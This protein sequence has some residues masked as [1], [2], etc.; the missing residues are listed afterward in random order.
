MRIAYVTTDPGIPPFGTKG[1]SI[2]V[3]SVLRVLLA[4]G[5]QVTLFSPCLTI[6]LAPEFAP[7]TLHPLPPAPRGDD[8]EAR[9]AWSLS[10]NETLAK[11]LSEAG[12]FDLVYER[13]ALF[14]HAAMEFAMGAGIPSALELNAPLIA[15][16]TRHRR[17]VRQPDAEASARRAFAAARLVAAVSPA[18]ADYARGFGAPA[19]RVAVIPNGVEAGR[20]ADRPARTGPFTVGFVG[21]LKPWHD[22]ATLIEAFALLKRDHL[23]EARL[24]IVGDGPQQAPIRARLDE[25]SLTDAA[26]LTGAVQ[27]DQVPGWLA[28]MHVATA[29]YRGDQPF[30][31][32]PLKLYEYMAAALPVVASD[33]GDLAQVLDHGRLGVI[34]PPDDPAALAHALAGLA[35][36]PAAAAQ[37]GARARAE[38]L[39][40]HGWDRIVTQIL[41]RASAPGQEAA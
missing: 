13:H 15:E 29:P 3:Q 11:A 31:F 17:M 32:S 16:Q 10:L 37:M 4:M 30:Y 28:A 14:A 8:A 18:V 41:K 5:H 24:L 19:P 12:P 22:T 35:R 2:H 25:L 7:V 21:T 36:D 38:V 27:P 1:A 39:A 23:P 26:H 33:V 6:P 40:H 34:V 9:A 20:F